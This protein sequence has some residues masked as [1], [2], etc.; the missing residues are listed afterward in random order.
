M[1]EQLTLPFRIETQVNRVADDVSALTAVVRPILQATLYALKQDV[2]A[3]V[4]GYENVKL[5]MLPRLYRRGDGDCGL[6]FEY[7]VH[8]A[9]NRGEGSVLDRIADALSGHCNVPG[10]RPASIL[11]GLEKAGAR[12]LIET[13][14]GLLTVDSSL[15]YGTR[16]RPVKLQRHLRQLADAFRRPDARPAL[17]QSISGLWKADLFLGTA[18]ADR[19]VG[20]SVKINPRDL[21]GARGLRIGVVP[22][23]QGRSD[24]I[25][26][27]TMRNLVIC[28]LPHD[29]EFME[30]FY[31]GWGIVQQVIEADAKLPPEVNLPGP[32]ERQV[33]RQLVE[34][35]EFPV[36]DVIGALAPLAQPGLLATSQH[37]ASVRASGKGSFEMGA[38]LAP[39]AILGS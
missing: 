3:E 20:T 22:S 18:D 29:G 25:T 27:D 26:H 32:L 17:P 1:H 9:L 28:P 24:A 23:R 10:T 34:R 19:W 12:Q 35:R 39:K 5:K 36:V 2:V 38:V 33:A 37:A 7:A 14:A 8:D 4:G 6:S 16:G 11:F 21:E 31:R 15:L 13:S 30:I